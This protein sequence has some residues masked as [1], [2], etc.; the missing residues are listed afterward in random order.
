MATVALLLLGLGLLAAFTA[1]GLT[2]WREGQRRAARVALAA[3]VMLS[4][5]FFLSA[6]LPDPAKW[7]IL[8]VVALAAGA[9]LLLFLL[10]VGRVERGPDVPQKRFD[11]RDIMFARARLV[12]GSPEYAAFYALRPEHKAGDDKTRSLPGLLSPQASRA[13]PLV[14]SATE[15][16]FGVTEALRE[17]VDGPLALER[18]AGAQ[19]DAAAMSAYVKALARY[20]GAHSVGI[21][22]LQPYHVYTH[23]G[24]GSGTYGA[25][26]T[27]DHRYAVAFTVEMD[28]AMV[29]TAPAAPIT[30]ESARQYVEAAKIA[31]QLGNLM[32]LLGFPARAHIDGN[33]RVIAPLV[34]RDAGLGEIGRMGLLMTPA[35]GPRVRL[36][37]V[38]TDLP[39]VPDRRDDDTS[40]LDFCRICL[41]CAD[42]CPV[43]AIPDG[44]R[45]I[46]DGA[47]RWRINP[48]I[49]F[50]YW[51]VIGTDCG[52]CMDVCPYSHPNSLVHNMVRW[53]V[54]RSGAAR[55][56]VYWL[57][58]LFYGS[59]PLSKSAPGWVP[60]AGGQD[61]LLRRH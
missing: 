61:D 26:V 38:T 35:L 1:F 27:L 55:R 48:D 11:E 12:P 54:R 44:D 36:G 47:L 16:S 13:N 49:C 59:K 15:A 19:L 14:F 18:V 46:I 42:N 37:V 56:G 2:A 57:D 39:L 45:E 52:R 5:P 41:K 10:P 22:E 8:G 17:A 7:A 6:L 21:A 28:H 34:A 31:I 24:R 9:G 3:A 32:R 4:C 20:H 25:P 58:R 51:N 50:R 43:R 53:A 23:I 60:F 33:Y 30:L 29:G 40:M